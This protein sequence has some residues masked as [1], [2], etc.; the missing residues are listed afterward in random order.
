M[1]SR[2]SESG[3]MTVCTANFSRSAAA[4]VRLSLSGKMKKASDNFVGGIQH[5]F[6]EIGG[7]ADAVDHSKEA[8]CV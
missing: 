4:N 7:T 6:F 5:D 2:D 3:G 8:R 1:G